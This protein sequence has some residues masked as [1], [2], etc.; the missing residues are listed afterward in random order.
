M[1]IL[2]I[3]NIISPYRIPV[4]NHIAKTKNVDFK[5][6]FLAETE[7]NR[8]WKIYKEKV[9]FDYKVLKSCCLF[10]QSKEMPIYMTWGLWKELKRFKPEAICIC[11][12]Q[13]LATLESLIY[14]KLKHVPIILWAG[15]HLVSGSIKN[16]L[17]QFYKKVIIPRFDYYVTYGTAASEQIAH[18]GADPNKIVTGCNTSDVEWFRNECEQIK[19]DEISKMKE[20]YPSRNILYVGEF[21]SRKNVINLIKAFA[22]LC[23]KDVGL[24]LVGKGEE[25]DGYLQYIK[26]HNIENVFFEGFI[27][28]EEI[29]KYYKMSDVFVLPSLNEVWGLVVNE[30]M[31]CGLPVIS[32]ICAGASK[33]IVI[34][35]VNGYHFDP[36]NICELTEK[37]RLVISDKDLREKMG[38]KSLEIIKDKTPQKY[39][40]KML[41]AIENGFQDRSGAIS[42]S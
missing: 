31:A 20:R 4:F 34:D 6:V 30:A 8:N 42:V 5:V 32:S 23:M 21:V 41:Q 19:A 2:F 25:K 36:N 13:Y 38:V 29:V 9:E 26:E 40:S 12:Y 17:A 28:K 1:K 24:I 14:A 7:K 27:Q 37:L 18:Y 35:K 10:I 22:N 33:D 11:G 15:S 39:A 3:T 16:R